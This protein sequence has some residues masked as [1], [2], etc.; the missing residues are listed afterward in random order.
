MGCPN[1]YAAADIRLP[2]LAW[3]SVTRRTFPS[4]QATPIP[5]FPA[6]TMV[7]GG[8]SVPSPVSETA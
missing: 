8:A 4:P 1:K 3:S 7:P 6:D 2:P 5:Y